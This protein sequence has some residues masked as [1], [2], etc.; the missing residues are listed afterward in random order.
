MTKKTKEPKDP[1]DTKDQKSVKKTVKRMLPCKL[2]EAALAKLATDL[3]SNLDKIAALEEKK[4]AEAD[5]I[6]GDIG[7]LEEATSLLRD[8]IRSKSVD[9]EVECEE[10][11]DY[12]AGEMRVM[13][14]DTKEVFQKRTLTREEL[15]LPLDA[16]KPAGKLLVMDGGKGER[17][18]PK[19]NDV[20]DVET[21]AGWKRGKV[22]RSAGNMIDV[23]VGDGKI[24]SA[25]AD[26]QT[27][28][29]PDEVGDNSAPVI[30]KGDPLKAKLGDVAAQHEKNKADAESAETPVDTEGHPEVEKALAARGKG[31][32]KKNKKNPNG[33]DLTPPPGCAF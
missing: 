18:Q 26:G 4:K 9:R 24:E 10:V 20:I 17:K 33:A 1:K 27:W 5:A 21:R 13:R 29:W 30:E 12:R 11:T 23:D 2:D 25:P 19:P 31:R 6:K 8:K 28:R 7:L 14:L 15:Q 16:Q 32:G 3:G 22:M